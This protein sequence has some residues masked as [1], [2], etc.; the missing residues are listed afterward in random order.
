MEW[1]EALIAGAGRQAGERALAV[2]EEARSE[3]EA[4][5]VPIYAA[6]IAARLSELGPE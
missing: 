2:L 4:M 3:F 5:G 6:Q 1:A